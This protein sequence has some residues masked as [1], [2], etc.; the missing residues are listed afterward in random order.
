MAEMFA[1]LLFAD[2]HDFGNGFCPMF[3]FR[4]KGYDLLSGRAHIFSDFRNVIA[5]ERNSAIL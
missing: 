3:S 2:A 4:Q 1:N 5:H